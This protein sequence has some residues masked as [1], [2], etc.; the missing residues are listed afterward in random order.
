MITRRL[1]FLIL[2]SAIIYIAA[3]R[4]MALL[5]RYSYPLVAVGIVLA[6]AAKH[7][8]SVRSEAP[9][10]VFNIAGINEHADI[11]GGLSRRIVAVGDLHGDMPNALK[12]LQLGGVV[13]EYGNWTGD[14]DYLVQTGDIIDRCVIQTSTS[15]HT[16]G[17]FTSI[18][19][20]R[21]YNQAVYVDGST[22][23][24]G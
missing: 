7:Q 14:V 3:L 8:F 2:L 12:V 24:T 11:S 16:A 23:S 5:K 22:T 6:A 4:L 9:Q 21:R 19:Q 20:R 18:W 17:I 1:I 10:I 13:D 15:Q